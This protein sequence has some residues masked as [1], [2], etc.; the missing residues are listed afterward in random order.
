MRSALRASRD[1]EP[2]GP[3]VASRGIADLGPPTWLVRRAAETATQLSDEGEQVTVEA[4]AE[5]MQTSV[6]EMMLALRW[7]YEMAAAVVL[8]EDQWPS[9][10]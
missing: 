2:C 1:C 10:T 7:A 6:D 3:P 4:V 9:S 8:G 5:F